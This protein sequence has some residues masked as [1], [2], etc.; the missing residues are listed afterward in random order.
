MVG[1][2]TLKP[3]HEALS[4]LASTLLNDS[5]LVLP[6]Y[7]V[8]SIDVHHF[9]KTSL[10]QAE[11]DI[12]ELALRP[13]GTIQGLNVSVHRSTDSSHVEIRLRGNHTVFYLRYGVETTEEREHVLKHAK[14]RA[15]EGAWAIER[16][17]AQTGK[18]S[19]NEWTRVQREELLVKGRVE[20]FQAR[21]IRNIAIYTELADDPKNVAFIQMKAGRDDKD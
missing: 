9:I 4:L 14:S 5:I 21:Y 10:Q 7:N 19:V 17:L 6:R 1:V 13:E 3:A 18:L 20:E 8:H 2:T 11:D 12:L 15:L 16:E